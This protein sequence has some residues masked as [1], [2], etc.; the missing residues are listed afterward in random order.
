MN[1][2]VKKMMEKAHNALNNSYSP[3][4]HFKVACCIQ[5][6]KEDL[7]CG[8]NVENASYSVTLCAEMA[9]IAQMV[10]AGQQKIKSLV[11]IASS[12][13]LCPP[14]GA[15]RQCIFEFSTAETMVYLCN[16]EEVLQSA[17]IK[18][19]L[20]LNFTFNPISGSRHD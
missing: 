19:L 17:S 7:F 6:E 8:V 13:A 12:N 16:K 5:T 1:K 4:S 14:C 3:Y 20:P 2:T 15:C 11:I 18:E 9:A 10:S